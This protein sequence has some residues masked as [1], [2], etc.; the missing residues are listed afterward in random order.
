LLKT[1]NQNQNQKLKQRKNTNSKNITITINSNNKKK[2][3]KSG[4]GG[5]K[6]S[7]SGHLPMAP[8]I[9]F[10]LP[11]NYTPQPQ[12]ERINNNI[13]QPELISGLLNQQGYNEIDKEKQR[14]NILKAA[15]QRQQEKLSTLSSLSTSP[16]FNGSIN[17]D[18]VSRL[19][20]SLY[21][22]L[23]NNINTI[24]T[25]NNNND[26]ISTITN[27]SLDNPIENPKILKLIHLNTINRVKKAK[28][29]M[30]KR[31]QIKINDGI[32]NEALHNLGKKL[33]RSEVK[34][35][36]IISG[37]DLV[38]K[39]IKNAIDNV[40]YYPDP[41]KYFKPLNTKDQKTKKSSL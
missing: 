24:N 16:S 25:T 23:E 4:G 12:L 27:S 9:Q 29:R 14:Q 39:S 38:N 13:G 41:T 33:Q 8:Q 17:D 10:Q 37:V 15:E 21:N 34:H 31:D 35:N 7:F 2:V 19:Y 1:Q 18:S 6:P 28:N 20:G 5:N 32:N 36:K 30:D 26:D 22:S 40:D 11:P 3:T